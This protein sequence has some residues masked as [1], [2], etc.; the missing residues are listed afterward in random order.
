MPQ[1]VANILMRLSV[2]ETQVKFEMASPTMSVP[3]RRSA[4]A[5]SRTTADNIVSSHVTESMTLFTCV[6]TLEAERAPDVG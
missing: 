4:E 1:L 3:A 5:P 6:A 2:C